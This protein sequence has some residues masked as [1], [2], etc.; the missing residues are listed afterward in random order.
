MVKVGILAGKAH[1]FGG[2]DV[3]S[4]QRKEIRNLFRQILS[5]LIN[6]YNHLVMM[7]GLNLG[8]EQDMALACIEER[9]D[10]IGYIPFENH[11]DLWSSLPVSV[12]ETYEHLIDKALHIEVISKGDFSPRKLQ[13]QNN[14]IICDSDIIIYQDHIFNSFDNHNKALIEKLNKKIITINDYL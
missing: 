2:Y 5:S 10:Y 8:I 9:V 1:Y 6:K 7:N 13:I 4:I 11:R 12:L 3:N 14:R